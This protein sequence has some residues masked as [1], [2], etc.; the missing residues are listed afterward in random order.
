MKAKA[1]EGLKKRKYGLL[2]ALLT[3]CAA[4]VIFSLSGRLIGG[5]YTFIR[6]DLTGQ[7]VPFIRQFL[8][9]LFGAE[10]LDYSFYISMGM[11][12]MEIYAYYC[13]SPFNLF[14]LLIEDINLASVFVVFSKLALAA[15]TFQWFSRTVK[16][17]NT[18]SS[19]AFSMAYALC[20]YTVTYYHNI[21]FLDSVY[22]LPVIMG[23]V[24]LFVKEGKWRALTAAYAY[25]FLVNFYTAYMVGFFS[26]ILL[27]AMMAAEYGRSWKRYAVTGVRFTGLVILAALMGAAFLMPAAYALL[28]NGAPDASVFG[29]LRLMLW[30][31]YGNLFL[32]QMQTLEGI[33]PMIYCGV[34]VVYLVP[35]FFMDGHYGR[36]EKTVCAVLFGF[37]II[38][39]LWLPGYIFLHCFDAPDSYGYR[40][41]FLYS[42]LLAAVCCTQWNRVGSVSP[43]KLTVI[44]VINIILYYLIYLW[45]KRNLEESYQ[46]MS[47]LGWELNILFIFLLLVLMRYAQRGEGAKKKAERLLVV[48]M[49]L[50]L[51]VNGF[52]CVTRAGYLP[53]DHKVI[54]NNWMDSVEETLRTIRKED[55]G[56]YRIRYHNAVAQDQ[57]LQ[58]DYMD[59]PYFSTIENWRLRDTLG[60]LG[61]SVSPRGILNTGGTP[62]TEMLFA[63]RYIVMAKEP[64]EM[65]TAVQTFYKNETA[66]GLGYMVGEELRDIILQENAM[67]NLNLVLQGMTGEDIVCMIPYAGDIRLESENMVFGMTAEETYAL[68]R[69]DE[70]EASAHLLYRLESDS[71]YP[72]YAYFSQEISIKDTSMPVLYGGYGLGT[73]LTAPAILP[74]ERSA[75][76]DNITI[77]MGEGISSEGWYRNHYFAYYDP[78]AL[79]DAYEALKEHQLH[80]SERRGSRIR[81]TV[82]AVEGRTLLFTSIPYDKGWRIY[83]DGTE[84][85]TEA[86]INGAF[87]GTELTPGVHEIEMVYQSR[88]NTVSA[89]ISAAACAVFLLSVLTAKDGW[90]M[91]IMK[92]KTDV[93]IENMNQE[94]NDINKNNDKQYLKSKK[95][96]GQ[97]KK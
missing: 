24:V 48:L 20:G 88:L 12:A 8:N 36:K 44:A 9:S 70:T 7:Y 13:L 65:D 62:V 10:D 37:L 18:L 21:L 56:I 43:Q 23:L 74:M 22:M 66:L 4:V 40:F 77:F 78:A 67:E 57:P 76:G 33:F 1:M 25:L 27:L 41:G 31:L 95:T 94:K 83:V 90:K 34:I 73:Y 26:F 53:G 32:G 16:K 75:D 91:K 38:C 58:F 49:T 55:D 2:A 54:Y 86:L 51:I 19:V 14:Y 85:G 6:G 81:G 42:F 61:Y 84:A 87:L 45:Q 80:I 47:V 96:A 52:F 97:K 93:K 46:S 59:I 64:W 82:E 17:N 29:D 3:A 35:L 60:L 15:Y 89:W 28:W 69:E 5:G 92:R 63:Q 50:E 71:V 30:D 79:Q 68:Y 39:S 72:S 11:S